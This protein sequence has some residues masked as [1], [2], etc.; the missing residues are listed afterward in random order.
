MD[1]GGRP[2]IDEME[3]S[4]ALSSAANHKDKGHLLGARLDGR[5]HCPF[6]LRMVLR[7]PIQRPCP[8]GRR[9]W[10]YDLGQRPEPRGDG[11]SNQRDQADGWSCRGYT[12]SIAAKPRGGDQTSARGT[13]PRVKAGRARS[14]RR[15]AARG[16]PPVSLARFPRTS[17]DLARVLPTRPTVSASFRSQSLHAPAASHLSQRDKKGR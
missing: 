17:A 3:R 8:H 13:P 16:R 9:A 2:T 12:S 15:G 11:P 4:P 10:I 7:L 5:V 14:P 6:P 1:R